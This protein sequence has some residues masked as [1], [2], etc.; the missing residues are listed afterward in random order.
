MTAPWLHAEAYDMRVFN[1]VMHDTD[2]DGLGDNGGYNTLLEYNTLYRV[3]ARSHLVEAV[4]GLRSCDG[5]Q[6]ECAARQAA[7]GWGTAAVGGEEPI[8]NRNVFVFNNLIVNGAGYQ[9]RWQHLAH[10][11]RHCGA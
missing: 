3:G 2:E 8:P 10:W 6:S 9:S 11:H 5:A 4:F 7:G 1:N